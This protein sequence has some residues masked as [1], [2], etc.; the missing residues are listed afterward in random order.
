VRGGKG[1]GVD[2]P[3]AQSDCTGRIDQ[4]AGVEITARPLRVALELMAADVEPMSAGERLQWLGDRAGNGTAGFFDPFRRRQAV[5]GPLQREFRK[6]HEIGGIGTAGRGLDQ[7]NHVRDVVIDD[8][9]RTGTI[10]G[11]DSELALRLDTGRSPRL[12]GHC[13]APV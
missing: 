10:G 12:N 13:S 3:V 4:K 11:F 9:P 7:P 5:W 1:S 2:A 6:N 8:R